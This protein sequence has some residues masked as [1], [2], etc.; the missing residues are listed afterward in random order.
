MSKLLELDHQ[1]RQTDYCSNVFHMMLRYCTSSHRL[2]QHPMQSVVYT[3]KH[4]TA[5]ACMHAS[6]QPRMQEAIEKCLTRFWILCVR[7]GALYIRW[8]RAWIRG[9][10]TSGEMTG[11]IHVRMYVLDGCMHAWI[12]ASI[13]LYIDTYMWPPCMCRHTHNS[14]QWHQWYN[15][16][17]SSSCQPLH[18]CVLKMLMFVRTCVHA[19]ML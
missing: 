15:S 1:R 9:V 6:T 17:L 14:N 7:I 3:C 11:M 18:H 10:V 2:G 5:K 19:C 16:L 4:V 12:H 8:C 13:H